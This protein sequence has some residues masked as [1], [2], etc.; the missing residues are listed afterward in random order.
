MRKRFKKDVGLHFNKGQV[1]DYDSLT[2]SHIERNLRD[3]G[4]AD[5]LD[6]VAEEVDD[7]VPTT[8]RKEPAVA[9]RVAET[10]RSTK[11]R[12]AKKAGAKKKKRKAKK[13]GAKK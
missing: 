8:R 2:W 7:Q 5:S 1:V 10:K 6:D 13:V 3:L 11:K 12:P 9:D 4:L